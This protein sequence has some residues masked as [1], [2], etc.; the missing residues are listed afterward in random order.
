M[1][2]DY[3]HALLGYSQ[4]FGDLLEFASSAFSPVQGFLPQIPVCQSVYQGGGGHRTL[5]K[6]DLGVLGA[7]SSSSHTAMCIPV[8]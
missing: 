1:S 6:A 7:S 4:H 5:R 2:L 3:S 8:E